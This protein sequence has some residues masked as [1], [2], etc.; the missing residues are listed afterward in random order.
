MSLSVCLPVCHSYGCTKI[1]LMNSVDSRSG[2]SC[3][4]NNS[5]N[6][7]LNRSSADI[8]PHLC[9]NLKAKKRLRA[10]I[11]RAQLHTQLTHSEDLQC[12]AIMST[13]AEI[14]QLHGP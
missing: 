8:F 2:I 9:K 12:T 13:H 10:A 14:P 6:R 7:T 1:S 5:D 4:R 11:Q 3:N